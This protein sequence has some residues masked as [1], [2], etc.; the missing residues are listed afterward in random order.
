[1]AGPRCGGKWG[2]CTLDTQVHG[3]ISKDR[4]AASQGLSTYL[5]STSQRQNGLKHVGHINIPVFT[6]VLKM[7]G[8]ALVTCED[9]EGTHS[10]FWES[11]KGES[12][13]FPL[14]S[15]L[16]RLRGNEEWMGGAL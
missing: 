12:Q 8:L 14:L 4:A 16:E 3:N 7:Q 11:V 2:R 9:G 1:M 10:S 15:S 13:A 6:I 5:W